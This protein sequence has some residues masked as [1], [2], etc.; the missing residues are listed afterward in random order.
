[1]RYKYLVSSIELVVWPLSVESP[2]GTG[3][4]PMIIITIIIIY[5]F[6]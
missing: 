1:M 3:V 5:Q 4:L 2:G 6:I